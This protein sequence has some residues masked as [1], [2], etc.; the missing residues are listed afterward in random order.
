MLFE[1]GEIMASEKLRVEADGD[2]WAVVNNDAAVK[3]TYAKRWRAENHVIVG[4]PCMQGWHYYHGE[5]H[6]PDIE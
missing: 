6:E 4:C 1:R 3:A 2:R 5:K